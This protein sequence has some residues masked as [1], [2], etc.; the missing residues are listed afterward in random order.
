MAVTE[1]WLHN[2][3]D[4]EISIDGYNLFRCDRERIKKSTRG[5]FSGG[6]GCYVKT[7]LSATMEKIVEFSN[8]VVELLG[9]YSKKKNILVAV[10]Y[11]QPED[12]KVGHRS[13]HKELQ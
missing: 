10:I 12:I 2:H 8:G 6:V 1:T 13:T 5:R 3:T 11:R 4:A 9:L 7:E